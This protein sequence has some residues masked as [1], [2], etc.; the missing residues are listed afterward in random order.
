MQ[1]VDN[2]FADAHTLC[3]ALA[4]NLVAPNST[5]NDEWN[6]LKFEKNSRIQYTIL[7]CNVFNSLSNDCDFGPGIAVFTLG[8]SYCSA[9]AVP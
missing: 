3:N 7:T 1:T 5:P 8:P 4:A 2:N 6:L 9:K